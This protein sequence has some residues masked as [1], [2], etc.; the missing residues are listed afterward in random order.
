MNSCTKISIYNRKVH[1]VTVTR[2]LRGVLSQC[3]TPQSHCGATTLNLSGIYY[4]FW[5]TRTLS[6][7][8]WL[9]QNLLPFHN[10]IFYQ[11]LLWMTNLH[12]I[13][14]RMTFVIEVIQKGPSSQLSV[15]DSY[16]QQI[17]RTDIDTCQTNNLASP[18]HPSSLQQLVVQGLYKPEVLPLALMD[19]S[20]TNVFNCFLKPCK[21]LIS[22]VPGSES[23]RA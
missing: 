6:S 2:S 16:Q 5:L 1:I 17:L 7:I 23:S 11:Q 22:T 8:Q 3:A 21:L 13:S 12:M 4:S 20:S 19:F 14:L 18:Q 9:I 15:S 10:L